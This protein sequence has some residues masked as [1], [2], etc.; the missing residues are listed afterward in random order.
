MAIDDQ[1]DTPA[2]ANS[3]FSDMAWIPGGDAILH[4]AAPNYCRRY[5]AAARF[6]KPIDTPD[7]HVGFRCI[8]RPVTWS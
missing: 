5:R 1:L 7:C 2:P 8:V 6:P 3:P 4:E